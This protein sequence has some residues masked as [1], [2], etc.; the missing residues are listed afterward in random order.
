MTPD[1]DA[2][3]QELK[4]LYTAYIDLLEIGRERIIAA[5]GTC[6]PVEV[7]E[8]GDPALNRVRAF[9]KAAS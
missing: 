1:D 8:Q 5:G 7:M 4:R 2:A 6:D 9:L 3:R